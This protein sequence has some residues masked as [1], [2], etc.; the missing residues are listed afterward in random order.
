M[1]SSVPAAGSAA[2]SARA[3][4]RS[5]G[6]A[7]LRTLAHNEGTLMLSVCGGLMLHLFASIYADE[8]H[9]QLRRRTTLIRHHQ[10][11]SDMSADK[12]TRL[13][14]TSLEVEYTAEWERLSEHD[15]EVKRWSAWHPKSLALQ[16]SGRVFGRQVVLRAWA[17][18]WLDDE[19]E[20]LQSAA[21]AAAAVGFRGWQA[22]APATWSPALASDA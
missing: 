12:M 14:A 3:F 22:H 21:A 5:S 20:D 9:E 8:R 16:L 18:E 15:R 13:M 1:L 2:T 19:V 4:L 10:D 7:V 6:R 11:S 17:A